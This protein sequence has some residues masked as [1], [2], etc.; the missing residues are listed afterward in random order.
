MK[1]YGSV[2]VD[3]SAKF[4]VYLIDFLCRSVEIDTNWKLGSEENCVS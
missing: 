2:S 1:N 4:C 3:F